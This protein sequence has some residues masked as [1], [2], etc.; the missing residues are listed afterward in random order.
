[1]TACLTSSRTAR[2]AVSSSWPAKRVVSIGSPN[3]LER[4]MHPYEVATTLRQRLMERSVRLN[5]GA[6]YAVVESLR[7]RGLIEPVQTERPGRLP[8][9]TIYQLTGAGRTEVSDWL[10]DLISTPATE[11]PQFAAALSFLPALP[12]QQVADLLKQRLQQLDIE[13]AQA[14]A[15]RELMH[16]RGLPGLFQVEE[17]YRDR[18][19]AAEIDYVRSLIRDIESGTLDGADWWRQ[20]H[21][22]GI[23]QVPPPFDPSHPTTP[24]GQETEM[25]LVTPPAGYARTCPP[26]QAA[27]PEGR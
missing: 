5:Y 8:E 1:M 13:D 25:R 7:K 15:T 3:L 20:V 6:L 14:A 2:A 4:P 24:A 27:Q 10:A 12:P 22:R 26:I 23:D 16:K 18:L 19:R 9:R 11:Y 17:E 21:Q